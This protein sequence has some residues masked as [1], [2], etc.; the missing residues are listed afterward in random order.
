MPGGALAQSLFDGD[1]LPKGVGGLI[2]SPSVG[3]GPGVLQRFGAGW[4]LG[5]E[6]IL[7]DVDGLELSRV[8]G[9]NDAG[10]AGIEAVAGGSLGITNF[11][12]TQNS[13]GIN[14]TAAYGITDRL[15]VAAVIPFQWVR[16]DL[17][18]YLTYPGPDENGE[19]YPVSDLK[20]AEDPN[21]I[22]CPGGDFNF[23]LDD[24]D[25]LGTHVE[26]YRFQAGD[27]QRA[28]TSDCLGYDPI[29]DR[30]EPG[31]DGLFHGR[32][33]R[34]KSGFRDLALGAK[35]QFFRGRHIRLAALGF[36]VA[37]TGKPQDPNK[38]IDFKLGDGNWS[39]GFLLGATVPLG[40]VTIGASAGM[41]VELPDKERLRLANVSFSDD[42]EEA[43]ALGQIS[44]RDLLK[45][46]DE[47]A[48]QPIVTRYDVVETSRKLGNNLNA[49][50][51]VNVQIL[52]WLSVGAVFT[53]LH[54][55]R[56]R[57]DE[58][59]QRPEG[60]APYATE[61]EVRAR[62]QKMV[63]DG[64]ITD[65]KG[66]LEALKAGLAETVERKK[67]AYGWRTVRG[68]LAVGLG[69]NFNTLPMFAR[70]EFPIPIIAS[71][72]A[73]RFLAGQ[74]I[75]TPDAVQLNLTLPIAFGEI[76]DP[77]E[78]GYDDDGG[79]PPWP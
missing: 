21:A 68:Q 67:A 6:S 3:Y 59:H 57:I 19:P 26:G 5:R 52:E 58:I 55:F 50:S 31:D 69:L 4:Q 65:E 44:E 43:L 76:K 39:T 54:H 74:N 24:I 51:Y 70:G 46:I 17:D 60:A 25:R 72:S 62:V 33:A 1:T 75:D 12:A 38:L 79:G 37:G 47:G 36:V 30:L 20:V 61:A 71:I 16:Y 63:D 77:A 9:G 64:E 56:D 32:Q 11:K 78:W 34:T 10:K 18:A 40:R 8:L 53:F 14:F 42:L 66:R 23:G 41:E 13:F 35:Y 29:F 7:D 45:R 2:V 48:I 73:S 22:R 27:L 15:T 49:Y 28:L